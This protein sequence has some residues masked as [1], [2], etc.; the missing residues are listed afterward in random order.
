MVSKIQHFG[1]ENNRR[2]CYIIE[3]DKDPRQQEYNPMGG[4]NNVTIGNTDYILPD[5]NSYSNIQFITA[6]AQ[7]MS[8]EVT[9][10]PVIWETEPNQVTELDIYYEASN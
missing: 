3:V 9:K 4:G 2:V 5:T 10:N 1:Q 7:V 6:N 8:T